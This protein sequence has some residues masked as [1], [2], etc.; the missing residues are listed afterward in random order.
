VRPFV[1]NPSRPLTLG[2][3]QAERT[4]RGP[5]PGR[6]AAKGAAARLPVGR[7]RKTAG[8]LSRPVRAAFL[9]VFAYLIVSFMLQEIEVLRLARQVRQLEAEAAELTAAN[10]KLAEEIKY[11]QTPEFIERM[12][13]EELGL[14]WPNEIPYAPGAEVAPSGQAV[15]SGQKTPGVSGGP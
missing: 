9:I 5:A 7:P 6:S 14:V 3:H 2:T 4:P 13:R 12:A 10:Q 11:A 8:G 1:L 15:P